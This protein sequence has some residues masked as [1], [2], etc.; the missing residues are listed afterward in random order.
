MEDILNSVIELYESTQLIPVIKKEL[1]YE[2][3]KYSST[4]EKTWHVYINNEVI[5]KSSTYQINY[6]CPTCK[7]ISAISA[8]CFLRKIK[9]ER[10]GCF[11]CSV[12]RLNINKYPKKIKEI[13][14]ILSLEE[15]R[16]Q[17]IEDFNQCSNEFKENYTNFHLNLEEYT[18]IKKNIISFCDKTKT[19]INNYEFWPIYKA[20]NQMRFTSV[21]YSRSESKIFKTETPVLFC[22]N[23]GDTWRAKSIEQF[24]KCYKILCHDCKLCNRT[25]K[26]RPIKNIIDDTILYQSK[27]EEKFINWCNL[28]N[29]IIKNGPTVYFNFKNKDRKYKI[30]FQIDNILIEIKDYHIWHKKQILNGIWDAKVF[31]AWDYV[32]KYNLKKYIIMTPNNWDLMLINFYDLII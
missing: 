24:K 2:C 14:K 13:K 21:M 18:K 22:D 28:N 1:K 23:C 17:S 7:E 9:E 19:D 5:K 26:L 25:F 31:A 29:I 16:N 6:I 27:L 20:N 3:L 15:I 11:K 12:I 8:K 10:P 30:D 4:K 32:G